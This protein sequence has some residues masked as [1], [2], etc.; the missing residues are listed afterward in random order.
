LIDFG[1]A[2]MVGFSSGQLPRRKYNK[3]KEL[4]FQFDFYALDHF[5]L[6]LLYSCYETE[7][8]AKERSWEEE[9][10]LPTF[11]RSVLRKLLQL[12]DPYEGWQD[13]QKD[14]LI[15]LNL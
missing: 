11:I 1:L 12:D 3:M 4:S 7:D 14:F 9:L 13:I 8:H 5:I 15:I 2:R 10:E 6:F